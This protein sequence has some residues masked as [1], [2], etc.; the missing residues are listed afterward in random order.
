MGDLPR[1]GLIGFGEVGSSFARGFLAAGLPAPVAYDQP[2]N[3]AQLD[4]V[5][6]RSG[7]LAIALLAAPDGLAVCDIVFSCVPQDQAQAAARHCAGFLAAHALYVDVNSLDPS[8]KQAVAALVSAQNRAFVDGAIMSMPLNDLH[9]SLILAAGDQAPRLAQATEPLG[10]RIQVLG[11]RPGDAAGIKILRS[12]VVKGLEALLVESLTAAR[13]LGLDRAILDS[14][15]ELLGPQAG[16]VVDFLIRTHAVHARRRTL[17]VELSAATLASVGI[18]PLVTRAVAER[19]RRTAQDGLADAVQGT[20]P[21]DIATA[22][23]L[24]DTYVD[25]S[26]RRKA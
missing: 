17:E 12:V 9:R 24:F 6:Q 2:Q 13:R 23:T 25:H 4:L 11:T 5:R 10:M 8:G 21:A 14:L 18:D 19:L 16:P 3:P 20:L 15:A 26:V 22:I 1:I 7:Q